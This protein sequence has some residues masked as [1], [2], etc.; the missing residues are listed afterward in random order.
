MWAGDIHLL[1]ALGSLSVLRH[2]FFG[3]VRSRLLLVD[4][5]MNYGFL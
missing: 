1:Y 4:A 3:V 5:V 2:Q